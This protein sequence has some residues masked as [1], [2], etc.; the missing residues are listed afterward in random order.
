[1]SPPYL[2]NTNKMRRDLAQFQGEIFYFGKLFGE[3][4]EAVSKSIEAN[5][6]LILFT[7]NHGIPYPG[8]KRT[9]RVS[10]IQIPINIEGKNFLPFLNGETPRG[11][12]KYAYGQYTT[13]MKK[14][15]LSRC[16]ITEEYQLIRYLD[17]WSSLFYL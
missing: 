6:T 1:M 4:L 2:A 15:N 11:T 7:S 3:I 8:A 16:I 12:R 17:Q 13:D 14:D 9:A 10:G 5:K